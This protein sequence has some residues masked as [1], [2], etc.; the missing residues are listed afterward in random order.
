VCIALVISYLL[1]SGF[2]EAEAPKAKNGKHF[3]KLP[4]D[5]AGLRCSIQ[6]RQINRR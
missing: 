6:S 4:A 3:A 2:S 1:N 5:V